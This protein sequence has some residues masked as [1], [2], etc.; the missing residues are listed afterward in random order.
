MRRFTPR[1]SETE[2]CVCVA[3]WWWWGVSKILATASLFLKKHTMERK[4]WDVLLIWLGGLCAR[5]VRPS[6][7]PIRSD[8]SF[9]LSFLSRIYSLELL[10]IFGDENGGETFHGARER[11]SETL[12]SKLQFPP[13]GQNRNWMKFSRCPRIIQWPLGQAPAPPWPCTGLSGS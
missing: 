1:A 13:T 11:D 8:V 6:S 7:S 5:S 9:H 3:G 4:Q 12:S 2:K 10:L